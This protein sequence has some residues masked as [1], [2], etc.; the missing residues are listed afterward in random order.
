MKKVKPLLLLAVTSLFLLSAC[1]GE[2]GGFTIVDGD[3]YKQIETEGEE[4]TPTS[5]EHGYNGG[6]GTDAENPEK[7]SEEDNENNEENNNH[8]GGGS[9]ETTPLVEIDTKITVFKVTFIEFKDEKYANLVFDSNPFAEKYDFSYYT[10]NENK[11]EQASYVLKEEINEQE[12]QK[13]FLGSNEPGIYVIK[14]YNSKDIQ[15]GA[16]ELNI[17]L[18]NNATD[19]SYLSMAVNI[20]RVR[21]YSFGHSVQMHFKSIGDMFRRIFESDRINL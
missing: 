7:N 9:N 8:V 2:G 1:D 20:F 21:M 3:T 6:T 12:T 15:Y 5:T 13:L 17:R 18:K 19:T 4:R 11:L 14:F 16:S 10:V